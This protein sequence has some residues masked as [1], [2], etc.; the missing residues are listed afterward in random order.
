MTYRKQ[1]T[2][3][4]TKNCREWNMKCKLNKSKMQ[5][6]EGSEWGDIYDQAEEVGD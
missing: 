2:K 1:Y 6:F 3:L 5:I 4:Q